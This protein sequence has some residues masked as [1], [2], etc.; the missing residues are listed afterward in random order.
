MKKTMW[1]TSGFFGN[2]IE[3]VEVVKETDRQI[4]F[5]RPNACIPG[6]FTE[7]R[8]AKQSTYENFFGSWEEAKVFLV[9]SARLEVTRC[10]ETLKRAQAKLQQMEALSADKS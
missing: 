6:T 9:E 1:K 4:V 10:E 5:L 2:L 3:P 8:A 7:Q